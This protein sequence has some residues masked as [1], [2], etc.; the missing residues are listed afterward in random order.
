MSPQ[1]PTI[2]AR[3]LAICVSLCALLFGLQLPPRMT[4]LALAAEQAKAPERPGNVEI[5][6]QL[7]R[8]IPLDLTFHDEAG[9]DVRLGDLIVGPTLI[10]PVYYRCTNV[11]NYLQVRVANLIKT[12]KSQP[13]QDYR[14][15]SVSFD[16][17]ETPALAKKNKQMYLTA[18]NRPIPSDGWRFLTGNREAILGLTNAI[19]YRFDRRGDDFIHPVASVVV[20]GDGT[21]IRY[22]YGVNMLPKDLALAILEAEKGVVGTS[23][24]K[25]AEY[26][27]TYDPITKT[28]VLNL[29]R[30][31]ATVVILST[32]IFLAYLFLSGKKKKMPPQER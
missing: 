10:L 20:A 3:T 21:V 15:I 22:L 11:C 6:E 28:Y 2:R 26:C 23:I 8:K 30:I 31:S 7:G 18:M 12:V 9:N 14:I 29:L 24:R 16:E 5:D 1:F 17:R 19:G 25:L 32:G 27:F 4:G 13:G